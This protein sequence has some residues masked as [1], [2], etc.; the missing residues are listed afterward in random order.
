[1]RNSIGC[2]RSNEE[3]LRKKRLVKKRSCRARDESRCGR[4]R[5]TSLFNGINLHLHLHHDAV[6]SLESLKQLWRLQKS[7]STSSSSYRGAHST[8]LSNRTTGKGLHFNLDERSRLLQQRR[9]SRLNR[10]FGHVGRGL[11][12]LARYYQRHASACQEPVDDCTRLPKNRARDAKNN[13]LQA[14]L[15]LMKHPNRL[16][17]I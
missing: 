9:R 16:P 17:D 6:G 3:R 10:A 4:S 12:G 15:N 13:T 8:T 5:E 7:S 14:L 1:M 11:T 2:G